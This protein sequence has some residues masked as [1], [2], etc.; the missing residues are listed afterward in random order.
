MRGRRPEGRI[1][2]QEARGGLQ[3]ARKTV[4]LEARRPEGQKAR[5]PE[6]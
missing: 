6:G 2:V 5:R 3:R 1:E 4:Y